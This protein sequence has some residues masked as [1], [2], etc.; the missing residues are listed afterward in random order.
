MKKLVLSCIRLYQKYL[1]FDTGL[2]RQ[3]TFAPQTC[4]YT[5]TCSHYTYQAI[6]K[7]GILHGSLLGLKR[8]WRCR[9]D[10]PGGLDP[11]P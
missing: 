8:I 3:L 1:S 4:R 11:V 7:Y 9:P 10:L 5:P 6:E 2:L